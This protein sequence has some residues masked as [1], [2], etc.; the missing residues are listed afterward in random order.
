MADNQEKASTTSSQ[1]TKS[2][3]PPSHPT[4]ML[5]PRASFAEALFNNAQ[6]A[7][8]GLGLGFS[9]GPL[10]LVSNLFSDSDECKSFS[11]LLA[12]AM[13][14]PA[15]SGQF[16]PNLPEHV[17]RSSGDSVS[18]RGEMDFRFKQNRPSGL[19]IAQPSPIFAVPPGLTPGA[20]LDSPNLGLFSPGQVI[21]FNFN[22]FGNRIQLQLFGLSFNIYYFIKFVINIM[23]CEDR[24]ESR[25]K[26]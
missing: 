25:L 10:T 2:S 18:G 21:E 7:G 3:T 24:V 11:Q 1:L 12:G 9:P 22:F 23:L 4:I 19:V 20:L 16:R 13:A 5:P 17:E 26:Q 8:S 6:G 15:P 14:S